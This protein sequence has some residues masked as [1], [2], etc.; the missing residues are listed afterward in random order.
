[1]TFH[2]NYSPQILKIQSELLIALSVLF[3]KGGEKLTHTLD[4]LVKSIAAFNDHYQLDELLLSNKALAQY[5][6]SDDQSQL[7]MCY[8]FNRLFVGPTAPVAPP[9]ESVYLSPDHLIM[10][11]QTL[12]VRK[13]YTQE[14]LQAQ[15]QGHEPD[16]FIATELEF[17]AYLLTRIIDPQAAKN[18]IQIQHYTA[19]YLKF[20]TQHPS[21][22][23]GLFAQRIREATRHPVFL[24]LSEVLDT[25]TTLMPIKQEGGPL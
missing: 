13:I 22:W 4:P 6:N 24:A 23:L 10:G 7:L 2:E 5:S 8:E 17:A 25:L 16:D 19:L 1:M 20:W 3:A 12:A 21:L 11:D 18:D 14:N 9:Y 15:G